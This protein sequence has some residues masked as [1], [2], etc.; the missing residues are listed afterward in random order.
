MLEKKVTMKDMTSLQ[1]EETIVVESVF[2]EG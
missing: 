2:R 1:P